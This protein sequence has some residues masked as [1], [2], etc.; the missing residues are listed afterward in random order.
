MPFI[1]SAQLPNHFL[2]F[3]IIRR[4]KFCTNLTTAIGISHCFILKCFR[5]YIRLLNGIIEN[6][7]PQGV[8]LGQSTDDRVPVSYH[9]SSRSFIK[10]PSIIGL[11]K[12]ENLLNVIITVLLMYKLIYIQIDIRSSGIFIV[13]LIQP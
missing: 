3:C 5:I 2:T 13:I 9:I 6:F 12:L 1:L 4:I 7:I 11:I 8:I 10:Y